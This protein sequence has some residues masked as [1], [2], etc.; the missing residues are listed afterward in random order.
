M[1]TIHYHIHSKIMKN[2]TL[3]RRYAL[4]QY[5]FPFTTVS[6]VKSI[7]ILAKNF[8]HWFTF[9]FLPI[10]KNRQNKNKT[11]QIA[12]WYNFQSDL[13]FSIRKD[14]VCYSFWSTL[15]LLLLLGFAWYYHFCFISLLVLNLF[16][17]CL[18]ISY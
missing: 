6:G 9:Q 11:Y 10:E 5:S 13:Y 16:T 17:C 3:I 1:P 7:K 18:N 8:A 12:R 2:I 4:K 14:I 15:L